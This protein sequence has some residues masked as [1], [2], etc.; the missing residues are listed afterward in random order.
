M[1]H[2]HCWVDLR[3]WSCPSLTSIVLHR[4]ATLTSC[5]HP[6]SLLVHPSATQILLAL[7][8]KRDQFWKLKNLGASP[9]GGM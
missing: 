5:Y 2:P 7:L 6:Y 3:A 8:T 1:D 9:T 4:S